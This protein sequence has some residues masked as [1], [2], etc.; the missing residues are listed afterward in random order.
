M[1]RR[2]G[3]QERAVLAWSW[4]ELMTEL[5]GFHLPPVERARRS[6]A[7]D[8]AR[9]AL[10][11]VAYESARRRGRELTPEGLVELLTAST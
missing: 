3:D 6:L 5:V 9:R 10:D 7:L 1:A 2:I 11:D 4:L 8:E